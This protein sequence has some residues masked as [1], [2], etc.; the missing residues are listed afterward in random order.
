MYKDTPEFRLLI[1]RQYSR[2]Y[3]ELTSIGEYQIDKKVKFDDGRAKGTVAWKYQDQK[4]G[5]V[6]IIEDYSGFPFEI[7]ANEI[8]SEV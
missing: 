7:T 1:Y 6:Y 8:I 5:L 4:R 2:E 3:G